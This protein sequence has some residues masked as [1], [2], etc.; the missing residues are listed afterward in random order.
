MGRPS[1]PP[2]LD[3]SNY[4]VTENTQHKSSTQELEQ[5]YRSMF[6]HTAPKHFLG[7]I[8]IDDVGCYIIDY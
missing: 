7:Y 1:H 8:I 6:M 2:Q 4:K 5:F 3:Y